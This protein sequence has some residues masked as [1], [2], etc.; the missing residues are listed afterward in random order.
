MDAFEL[1]KYNPID[2]VKVILSE[3]LIVGYGYITEID[4]DSVIVT[5]SVTDKSFAEKV[6]C[7]FMS[8][9]DEKFS[10]VTRPEIGMRVVTLSPVKIEKRGFNSYRETELSERRSYI[11]NENP[12]SYSSQLA[13]CFPMIKAQ[14]HSKTSLVFD[15]TGVLLNSEENF[16]NMFRQEFITHFMGNSLFVFH[17]NTMTTIDIQG[18]IK[19]TFGMIEGQNGNEAEGEYVYQSTFGRYSK[20]KTEIEGSLDVVIGKRYEFPFKEN[21][22]NLI[23]SSAPVTVLLSSS[24]PVTMQTDSPVTLS[25]GENS[26]LSLNHNSPVEISFGDSVV[27][28]AVDK[29]YGLNIELKGSNKVQVTAE[30]GKLKMGNTQGT[31]KT[32]L[33]KI[34]DLCSTIQT[35]GVTPPEGSP[36]TLSL[37]PSLVTK[38]SNEL[39]NL[40]AE[41]LE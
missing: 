41:I 34:A 27:K 37:D 33:D 39:K 17:E 3:T 35:T 4:F 16:L 14:E 5:L 28:I 22:G 30:N 20:I 13:L 40:I 32:I 12:I 1:N 25:F 24:A 6:R 19:K 38:F 31:L 29:D 7:V 2:F 26:K 9:G 10:F 36:I 21:K 23:D 15:Q 18:S 8:F 11:F